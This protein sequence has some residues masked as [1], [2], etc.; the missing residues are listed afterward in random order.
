MGVLDRFETNGEL[1]DALGWTA[2]DLELFL[3]TSGL[4]PNRSQLRRSK[5]PLRRWED[6]FAA[7][8]IPDSTPLGADD[9]AGGEPSP[10]DGGRRDGER[11]P[12]PPPG[13]RIAPL[14]ATITAL[15]EERIA[16]AYGF[17]GGGVGMAT[18][19]PQIPRVVDEYAPAIGR[20]WVKAAEENEFAR[21]VVTMM[22]AGGATGE[23]V[24]AHVIMVGGILYVSGRAPALAGIYGHKFGPPSVVAPQERGG[25]G[26]GADGAG[27]AVGDAAG[28]PTA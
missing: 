18:G 17:I 22:S 1:L 20:A 11:P 4:E 14:P 12:T 10:V 25:G 9:G 21:R 27:D 3:S 15:A 6:A 13:A 7:L 24:M 5:R 19:N 23:L 28:S 8:P 16:H 26:D 2:E